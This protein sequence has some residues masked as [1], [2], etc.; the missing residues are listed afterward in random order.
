MNFSKETLDALDFDRKET[1]KNFSGDF[2]SVQL[3]VVSYRK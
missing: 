2:S 1:M 3:L